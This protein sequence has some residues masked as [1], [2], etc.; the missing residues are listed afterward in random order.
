MYS[1]CQPLFSL[2]WTSEGVRGGDVSQFLLAISEPRGPGEVPKVLHT[3]GKVEKE[4]GG[5]TL[6]KKKLIYSLNIC[7]VLNVVRMDRFL[8]TYTHIRVPHCRLLNIWTR[9]SLY[10]HVVYLFT[11]NIQPLCLCLRV[12]PRMTT[13]QGG[14]RV[15]L[16]GTW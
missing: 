15:Q 14:Y 12:V 7:K 3:I 9:L 5:L 8:F 1:C 2:D 16:P 11:C 4:K 10:A 6:E 13:S